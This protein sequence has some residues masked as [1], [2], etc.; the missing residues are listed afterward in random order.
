MPVKARWL[1]LALSLLAVTFFAGGCAY[2]RPLL[3]G[4]QVTPATISPNADGIDDVTHLYYAVGRAANVSIYLIDASGDRHYFRKEQ[5]RSPGKYDVYWGGVIN[6]PQVRQVAGGAGTGH[7]PGAARWRP[8]PGSLRPPTMRGASS[9]RRARSSFKDADTTLPDLHDFTVVPQEFTPNQ[10]GIARPGVDLL[11]PDQESR[12]G[13]GVSGAAGTRP[14]ASPFAV[15]DRRGPDG[16]GVGTRATRAITA[17]AT[18][19]AWI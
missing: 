2:L 5:R 12:A 3:T 8:I 15:S 7:Q 13:S 10:D 16:D 17:T 14:G 9:R 19:A 6:D 4:V 11:L 18:M 1:I